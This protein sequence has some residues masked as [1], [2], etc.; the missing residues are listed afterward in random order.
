MVRTRSQAKSA[1]SVDPVGGGGRGGVKRKANALKVAAPE[2]AAGESLV[3][4]F[5]S[6]VGCDVVMVDGAAVRGLLW[7]PGC[8]RRR[9]PW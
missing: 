8:R 3:G 6:E 2:A 1:T 7:K 4:N 5:G 9:M